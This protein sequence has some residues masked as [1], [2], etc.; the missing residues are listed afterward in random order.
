MREFLFCGNTTVRKRRGGSVILAWGLALGGLSVSATERWAQDESFRS[1]VITRSAI[2]DRVTE[3]P[4]GKLYLSFFNG[5]TLTGVRGEPQQ[6]AI[7]RLNADGSHDPSFNIGTQLTSAWGIAFEADGMILVGGLA[8]TES[9]QTGPANYRVFRFNYDGGWDSGYRSPV[10]ANIPRFMTLQADGKLLVVPSGGG[11]GVGNGG[12]TTMA[13]L[14]AHGE[15]DTSF[16]EPNLDWG[17]VFAPPVV[18]GDGKIYIGGVFDSVDGE[19]RPSVARL[20]ADGTLDTSYEPT[21]F[22]R[23]SQVR[24]LAVQQLGAN[25][26]KLVIAGGP[27]RV[28]ESADP[29]ANRPLIRLNLDGTI[30][31]SF[32]LVTQDDAGMYIRP[33]MLERLDDDSLVIAGG[34]VARFTA[35]GDLFGEGDYTRPY[36]STEFYWMEAL[37][38][39]S[40]IV[41]PQSRSTINDEP[42]R[43]VV[44]IAPD[45]TVDDGFNAPE[46]VGYRYPSRFE[47]L[48]DGKIL[49]WGNFDEVSGEERSGLV[50]LHANGDVDDGYFASGIQT[51]AYV[52]SADATSDGSVLASVYNPDTF[53]SSIL[54]LTPDGSE[55]FTFV[56]D[57]AVSADLGS[58]ETR[59]LSDGKVLVSGSDVQRVL[60]DT[61]K[62]LR[63]T[64]M[65]AIDSSFDA[66]GLPAL[67]EV[68]RNGDGSL[69][70]VTV[71]Y[72]DVL[73]EDD[74][75]RLLARASVG[76][77]TQ[78]SGVI[79]ATLV[80]INVDGSIDTSFEGPRIP[81]RTT[82]GFTTI[83]DAQ[84]SGGVYEQVATASAQSPFEGLKVQ[85]DGK[86]L[87]YGLF[88]QID[89]QVAA[90]L[91]RLNSDG[92]LDTTFTI[93][94]GAEFTLAND[95]T[96]QVSDVQI[97]ASGRI[98][99][100]G[101]FSTFDGVSASGVVQLESDG[102]VVNGFDSGLELIPYVGESITIRLLDADTVLVGGSL[103]RDRSG[104]FPLPF[105]RI[106]RLPEGGA[107]W[108]NDASFTGPNFYNDT[109][110]D[111]VTADGSGRLYAT[112]VNGGTLSGADGNPA[113]AVVRMMADG[114]VDTSFSIG[115]SL[116]SAWAVHP[117]ADGSILVGGV[118]SIE[119]NST[120]FT[121]YRMFKF[122]QIG[123]PDPGYRSPIF[124]GI[125]RFTAMQPDGKLIVVPSGN[126]G[127]NGGI[128]HIARLHADGSLDHDFHQVWV[129]NFIFTPPVL[130]ADGKI[131]VG[132]IF[133]EIDGIYR[134]AL[135]RL[136]ADGT[137][138]GDWVPTGF[139]HPSQIR[140]LAI[141]QSGANAGKLLVAGGSLLV[142][143]SAEPT[144]NRPVV[145]L[146]LDG[147]IDSSF[148]LVTQADA[149]LTIRPRLLELRSD[150][151]F[152]V[153]GS[154]VAR[155]LADG[156]LDTGYAQPM[157]SEEAFWFEMFADGSAIV[158]PQP[159]TT[160]E[161]S[162]LTT[163]VKF[164]SAGTLDNTFIGPQFETIHFPSR[165]KVLP[166]GKVLTWG[167]F[168]RVEGVSAPGIARLNTDG[169]VDTS[170]MPADLT[171]P[172]YVAFAE[173]ADD[174]RILVA[175][176][177]EN[178]ERTIRR[179]MPDGAADTSFT[180]DPNLGDLTGVEV[181][182]LGDGGVHVWASSAQRLLD[183]ENG[184]GRLLADGTIDST[185]DTDDD[186]PQ[187][188]Q[189]YRN[190]DGSLRSIV[191]GNFR[192]LAIQNDGGIIARSSLGDYPEGSGYLQNT[193]LR[194][195]ADGTSDP[196]FNAPIVWWST[197]QSFP[198]LTDANTNGGFP[199]Q[200]QTNI[201]ATP[202]SGALA[203][204]DGKVMIY[205]LFT[206]LNGLPRAGLARLNADGSVDESFDVG[207]GA[208]FLAAPGRSGSV[209]GVS[210]APGGR[211][212]VTGYFDTFDGLSVSGLVLLDDDGD[213]VDRF[214]TDLQFQPFV[215][216]VNGAETASDESVIVSGSFSANGGAVTAFHRLTAMLGFVDGGLPATTWF[217]GNSEV[218][219]DVEIATDRPLT[220]VWRK[221]GQVI[222]G[223][224]GPTL[225]I[226]GTLAEDAGNYEVTVDD[227]QG[228]V[229]TSSTILQQIGRP[230]GS[231]SLYGIGDLPGGIFLS[232][233]RDATKVGDVIYAVGTST[234]KGESTNG[235]TAVLWQSD[236]GLFAL[237][238]AEPASQ[239]QGFVTASAITPDAAFVAA[240]T[241]VGL[242]NQRQAV[243]FNRGD[244]SQSLLSFPDGFSFL[245]AA[246]AISD[247]G[248]ILYGFGYNADFDTRG[249]RFDTA[250]MIA[251]EVPLP[252]GTYDTMFTAGER[253]VSNDG[254]VV[255]GSVTDNA[256]GGFDR[257]FRYDHGVGTVV[258]P[259]SPD[260]LWSTAVAVSGDG[261]LTLMTGDSF[262][263][264]YG[265]LFLHDITTGDL[266]SLGS[267]NTAWGPSNIMGMTSDAT[268]VVGTFG[269]TE[270]GATDS[271]FRN[272]NGWFPLRAAIHLAGIDLNGWE[273]TYALG[274]SEDG[275]LVFGQG[276]NHG[277]EE[278][279]VVEFPA[280]YLAA[281]DAPALPP[282]DDRIVGTWVL[283]RQDGTEEAVIAFD[284]DGYY[285]HAQIAT[286]DELEY[287]GETG[288]ERGSYTFDTDGS[289][290]LVTLNDTNGDIGLG[291]LSGSSDLSLMI[292]GDSLV[293]NIPG[294][295][296]AA[297]TRLNPALGTIHGGW[298]VA[299]S[300]G[301]YSFG[302]FLPNGRFYWVEDGEPDEFGRPGVEIGTY[303]WDSETK[304]LT[305]SV[306][307]D[308][309][310]GWGL[311]S[312]GS[313]LTVMVDEAS[314]TLS[315]TDSAGTD[316]MDL[317]ARQVIEITQQPMAS[318]VDEGGFLTLSV[319]ASGEGFLQYQWRLNGEAISGQTGFALI[320]TQI[321]Q[322][323]AGLYDVVIT[324]PEGFRV[325]A[326]TE[327]VVN[328]TTTT[329]RALTTISTRVSIAEGGELFLPFRI[330]GSGDKTVLLRAVGPTL[331]GFG[332]PSFM[333][334]PRI[335]LVDELGFP[336]AANDDWSSDATAIADASSAV[337]AFGLMTES[338][339]AALLTM[340]PP[341]NYVAI[342]EGTGPGVVLAELYETD[343][344]TP[345]SRFVYLGVYAPTGPGG[346]ALTAGFVVPGSETHP[347][348][349]RAVGPGTGLDGVIGDPEFRITGSSGSIVTNNDDWRN[350][351]IV[352]DASTAAGAPPLPAGSLDAASRFLV[353]TGAY[354]MTVT[355][356]TS[357]SGQVLAEIYE[358]NNRMPSTTPVLLVPPVSR[359]VMAGFYARFEAM[360]AGEGP[361]S[362]QWFRGASLLS[363]ETSPTLLLPDVTPSDEGQYVLQITNGQGTYAAQ[364]VTL[365][366]V[367]GTPPM[368]TDQPD[369][370]T[371]ASGGM[372]TLSVGV[373]QTN[374]P[375][376]YQW[377][378]GSSGDTSAPVSGATEP[379]YETPALSTSTSYWVEVT[380]SIAA[381]N[382]DTATVT[383]QADSA[384]NATH[385][386]LGNGF[387]PGE[388]VTIT[389]TLNYEGS[390]S[391]FGWQVQLP[392]GWSY[393][394]S[395]GQ[396]VPQVQPESG[397]TGSLEWAYTSPAA[398]PVSFTYT[399]NV[400]TDA[401]DAVQI[402]AAVLFRDGVSSEQ[403]ITITPSPLVV[404][405][406]PP[407][408]SADTNGDFQLSLSELLRVIELYNTRFGTTRTGH[409]QVQD[410]TEDG[411]A[412]NPALSNS[413][414]GN[415]ARF[416]AADTNRDG[417]IGLSELLR[418][419]ELY[420]YREGTTRTGA[421]RIEGGSEDGFAP[422]P[423]TG[424]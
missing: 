230:M 334:D 251:E 396:N 327:L 225:F 175:I 84:F 296:G 118:A 18:A 123:R 245:S 134:P 35:D 402:T 335:R 328:T 337:G 267:P 277:D 244:F 120:G 111:R 286:E 171:V 320:L 109:I 313:P 96:A 417:K 375:F 354:T 191:Q 366:V 68:Y 106:V 318:P 288:M 310:G 174:G 421:Y 385:E 183:D 204:D 95:R 409:Y 129:S 388:T 352:V 199:G 293:L 142:D 107:N 33:R 216:G 410:G 284:A 390:A 323:D 90:G 326:A 181:G 287:G 93:G 137:L 236:S 380:N 4:D 394:A 39:G 63:L 23:P 246:T 40:V 369:D 280:G 420:N 102:S 383:V 213:V 324:S 373:S 127:G 307:F 196:N 275:T 347:L 332:V 202:F 54:K 338:K 350:A 243:R 294:E 135:A 8:G 185:F 148:T 233:V 282:V 176:M 257:A 143:T 407:N 217:A 173:V 47:V 389:T 86:I 239:G 160:L 336:V 345:S 91:A 272:A 330:E 85:S 25:A 269:A 391:S 404:S 105:H 61:T 88:D 140:G 119:D 9:F 401:V 201:A 250:N 260:G 331:D 221:D 133:N 152:M 299:Y 274:I 346:D 349:A 179:F 377:Y 229:I 278:G 419:I 79:D 43:T 393:A 355:D 406:A 42:A 198:T 422:G 398:S 290:G 155:F 74:S 315:I 77:Y 228:S 162:L 415:N 16:S 372:A 161:G 285:L 189:V 17:W 144:A 92:S 192:Q 186:F 304:S 98:W 132:G 22:T 30:D 252:D 94:S 154:S 361:L 34:G 69:N 358:I 131:Y 253:G 386:L 188:G 37:S 295:Q 14:F 364:A 311:S 387:R 270:A 312:Y 300:D 38:D 146:N 168:S 424:V 80:R 141:Q 55:D 52:E 344:N 177:D 205:G 184:I 15:L 122:D 248:S 70:S 416:H 314:Q 11:G 113:G 45:G 247:D 292:N 220:Y 400:P 357:G 264:P 164:D 348:L 227:G 178:G 309:D 301:D 167:R 126:N 65:G 194:L 367:G 249:I 370:T 423:E 418:V 208:Q 411:F 209:T 207:S 75:G 317:I 226:S 170:F 53:E 110:A 124:A 212:W 240:R 10:F 341:G 329:G 266:T 238:T 254:S 360:A 159:G 130:D 1:P 214:S 27:I 356:E 56:V 125:P 408:H 32:N 36:F 62:L 169:S 259:Q 306:D 302:A 26:D 262:A 147:T 203:Q 28:G 237:P 289:F 414:S 265:E 29:Q 359:T 138:D 156:E 20:N 397:Q 24:G 13:R 76:P 163:W 117:L 197:F 128:R 87:V 115:T 232:Q 365:T 99:V 82:S 255:V 41:P 235:D 7:V 50:R 339:D 256:G 151:S 2:A 158:P 215:G 268:V 190:T 368:I 283:Y 362:Y 100:A 363:G 224:T 384:I 157:L 58:L 108:L 145:R 231:A 382:S 187:L 403:N 316:V 195:N 325:S 242:G 180:V 64:G 379:N 291:D 342:V 19:F 279:F 258:L 66:S 340:L 51:P 222:T 405:P 101:Y 182:Q 273:L 308:T 223:E 218:R 219:L 112:F 149:G 412:A 166:S 319:E 103:R 351:V 21:G 305:T 298:S 67:G 139:G 413:E 114:T 381:V 371:V 89:G 153:V 297:L 276:R 72:L 165:F 200:V 234:A 374:G 73:G 321:T 322:G 6:G 83:F 46:L 78:R 343:L 60:D 59:L 48:D 353:A 97:D 376:T 211:L 136:N 399:L 116:V 12:I 121:H 333:L 392:T 241:R 31:S 395:A 57:S 71:G 5:S 172:S 271:Y 210:P 193:I 281:F 49:T 3:G 263:A 104:E 44:K 303:Q 206:E 378:E 81:W 150:D 261:T